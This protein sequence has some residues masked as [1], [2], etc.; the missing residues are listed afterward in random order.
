MASSSRQSAALGQSF[1]GSHSFA[2]EKK[3]QIEEADSL[4]SKLKGRLAFLCQGADPGKDKATSAGYDPNDRNKITALLRKIKTTSQRSDRIQADINTAKASIR[5][6]SRRPLLGI[7]GQDEEAR[8]RA[9]SRVVEFVSASAENIRLFY[10]GLGVPAVPE[11]EDTLRKA[12]RELPVSSNIPARGPDASKELA[13][14]NERAEKYRGWVA[15]VSKTNAKLQKAWESASKRCDELSQQVLDQSHEV[16]KAERD[17]SVVKGQCRRA[18]NVVVARDISLAKAKQ[19]VNDLTEEVRTL[20]EGLKQRDDDLGQ[21][22]RGYSALQEE[23]KKSKDCTST[24]ETELQ[25]V[26][27]ELESS[28]NS[29]VAEVEDLRRQKR[30]VEMEADQLSRDLKRIETKYDETRKKLADVRLNHA[31]DIG[32]LTSTTE[33]VGKAKEDHRILKASADGLREEL[34]QQSH[35]LQELLT[36]SRDKDSIIAQR[37]ETIESQVQ[38]ASTFLRHLSVNVESSAWKLVAENVLADSACTSTTPADWL[39]WVI[40]PSWSTDVSLDIRQDA[41]SPEAVALAILVTLDAKLADTKDLLTLL[42]RLQA[43]VVEAKSMVSSI[44]QL[45][46]R[47][48]TESVGDPRLHLMHRV[49]MCQI[50]HVLARTEG[51]LQFAQALDTVDPRVQRLVNALTAYRLDTSALPMTEALSYPGIALVG[52]NREPRGVIAVRP[53]DN[54]ICWVEASHISITFKTMR[55]QSDVG[56][57]IELPLDSAQRLSWAMTHV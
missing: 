53:G 7:D 18:E 35:R 48:F 5:E 39:P 50:L 34:D 22:R 14:A 42:H 16:S 45:T 49:A 37:D 2:P 21:M 38:K 15:G 11:M 54:G 51:A 9:S 52:F 8:K 3:T 46:V 57:F 31:T 30:D 24:T 13:S 23:L 40:F 26:R 25:R 55:L 33:E 4:H 32:R 17:L 29:H 6:R 41:R 12:L 47:A 36:A 20:K 43:S 1:V 19:S 27:S 44:T 28:R 56:S 10:T